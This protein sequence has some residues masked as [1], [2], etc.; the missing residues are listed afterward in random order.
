M[1]RIVRF[2]NVGDGSVF[3]DG[4]DGVNI[5]ELLLWDVACR[6]WRTEVLQALMQLLV[7]WVVMGLVSAPS[8]LVWGKVLDLM[9]LALGQGMVMGRVA[10]SVLAQQD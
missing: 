1:C 4:Q 9:V 3:V 8:V 2:N 10:P 6:R 5:W 7:L